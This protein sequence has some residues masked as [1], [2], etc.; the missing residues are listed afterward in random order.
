M[1]LILFW[2]IRIFIVLIIKF[3]V[4]NKIVI[5]KGIKLKIES[6]IKVVVIIN[7]LVIGL[8]NFLNEVICLFFLVNYLL[9]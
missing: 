1:I 9:R 5:Y 3:L 7:L 8:N 6:E 2:V 4:I